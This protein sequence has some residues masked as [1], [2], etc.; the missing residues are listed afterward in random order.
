MFA[1]SRSRPDS[2][3][4]IFEIVTPRTNLASL[5]SAAHLLDASAAD[6]PFSLEIAATAR[7]CCF[8]A[9][10]RSGTLRQLQRQLLAVYPQADLR[11]LHIDRSP[12]LDPAHLGEREQVAA[13]AL[14]LHAPSYLPIRTF[15]D[16]ELAG[17]R[18]P[19]ADPLLGILSAMG[20]LPEGWRAL[21]QLVLRPAPRDWA[22]GYQR[23]ALASPLDA[24]RTVTTE[25]GPSLGSIFLL[26]GAMLAVGGASLGQQW[27]ATGDWLHLGALVGGVGGGV[28]GL[29]ILRA[30]LGRRPLY[31]PLLVREK[32]AH[33]AHV[34]QLRLSVFA[35]ANTD[36][37]DLLA[38]LGRLTAAYRQF[39]LP[40]GNG[41]E[42]RAIRLNHVDLSTTRA[43]PL[44]AWPKLLDGLPSAAATSILNSQE[45]AGLWHLPQAQA[46]V[47]FLERTTARRWAP[48]PASVAAGCRVGVSVHQGRAIPVSIP[49]ELLRRH[50]LLVAKTRRGK[51]SLLLRLAQHVMAQR[52]PD[53]RAPSLILVDPHG[54]LARAAL[55]LV[56]PHRRDD[57]VYLDV[58]EA[59]R[60]FG[61]NLLDTG[62]GWDADRAVANALSVFRHQWDNFWGPR[63]EDVFR[64]V[65]QT[66]Y[67]A[68][69]ARCAAQPG[70][71]TE[72]YTLLEIP[73]LLA[74][75][76]FRQAV[77]AEAH[78]PLVN[79]WWRVHW[80]ILLDRRL[81]LESA[82]PVL[83]KVNRI[84]A[85]DASR[86][87]LG[88][89]CST[90]EPAAWLRDGR[91][92]LVNTAVGT[93]GE[94]T[95]ALIGGTLLNLVKLEVQAQAS[96]PPHRRR[97][98]VLIVDEFHTLPGADF[99]AFLGELAKFGS[100]LILASQTLARLE[101]LDRA[102]ERTLR[103]TLFSNLDGLFA[104]HCSAEDAEYLVPELGGD[105][106]VQD[107][108]GL[109][110]HRC[111]ARLS[112]AKERL[113]V[114]SIQL[115][116]P[117]PSDSLLADELADTSAQRHGKERSAVEANRAA[118]LA[119]IAATHVAILGT[120]IPRS[121]SGGA[122]QAT[123][124]SEQDAT[125]SVTGGRQGRARKGPRT[126][127][128]QE[129][130]FDQA[131]ASVPEPA[132][133]ATPGTPAGD[134]VM[135]G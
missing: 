111:Y 90:I 98:V 16:A 61:L 107:L 49:D 51:S 44:R 118:V 48:L 110:E 70:A 127:G 133:P 12:E 47:P 92:V 63:M 72:Q 79:E 41:L 6:D 62:L 100:N 57:V 101:M 108:M 119:R 102:H 46:D 124:A 23:L 114:F 83:S 106:A 109:G 66:L 71:R 33:A 38:W 4:E 36:A 80:D 68:N 116:P 135:E 17:E 25:Q 132:V 53:H 129:T 87:L 54:D 30:R 97:P 20:N 130:L 15:S 113:P 89:S 18:A 112:A 2:A 67:R 14:V 128:Q 8:L 77:L 22:A 99:E 78:D 52:G 76:A 7:G 45:L 95:A 50:L 27:Y 74:D 73:A 24:E 32:L 88:Q 121:P 91:L 40:S 105:I 13:C 19:Q 1:D 55:G 65:L 104:F 60:P 64:M 26:G 56:P 11:P 131:L 123:P 21:S 28:P 120:P 39:T 134:S 103:A 59:R 29:L 5:S 31:D 42:P 86:C 93:V 9:R 82:N 126:V 125:G 84:A 117:P 37:A 58:G 69:A 43:L 75:P 94:D 10:A 81:R 3:V 35:P 122:G 85:S 96:L 34:T 115:D